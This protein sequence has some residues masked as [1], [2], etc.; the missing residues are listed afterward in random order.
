MNPTLSERKLPDFVCPSCKSSLN[1]IT[2]S[3][4]HC[5][6]DDYYFEMKEDIWRFLLP[7][8][9]A[10]Y[11][12]F[13]EEYELIRNQEK[14]GSND[15]KYYRA[16]PY[17]DLAKQKEHG[18][19]VRSRSFDGLITRII[20]PFEKKFPLPLNILDMG[21]G[22]CWLSN[23]LSIR[24]HKVAAIDLLVNELDG[25]GA[26]RFYESD[27]MVIQAEFDFIPFPDASVDMVIFNASFHYSTDYVRTLSEALRLIRPEGLIIILDTPIYKRPESGILMVQERESQFLQRFGCRGNSLPINNFL[28]YDRLSQLGDLFDLSWTLLKPRYDLSWLLRRQLVAIKNRRESAKFKIIMG[29]KKS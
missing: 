8:R 10:Y 9:W 19:S 3:Q 27:F 21:A 20:E 7:D 12:K 11:Q 26:F 15:P 25:L 28:T 17:C 23:R 29:A 18:W 13:I 2:D 22:N 1:Q 5:A 16:L 14:R 6:L 24:G 4:L